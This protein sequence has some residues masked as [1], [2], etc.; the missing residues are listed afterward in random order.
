MS[1][2]QHAKRSF[3]KRVFNRIKSTGKKIGLSG[4]RSPLPAT[5]ASAA[6][7]GRQGA[8]SGTSPSVTS[9]SVTS[10]PTPV[11][12]HVP[13]SGPTRLTTAPDTANDVARGVESPN[14]TGPIA[15][16][17]TMEPT[18]Y[19]VTTSEVRRGVDSRTS[20]T[21]TTELTPAAPVPFS[22]TTGS[23]DD[24]PHMHESMVVPEKVSAHNPTLPEFDSSSSQDHQRQLSVGLDP[25]LLQSSPHPMSSPGGIKQH[26]QNVFI[27]EIAF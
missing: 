6:N 15:A 2:P 26:W 20:P 12:E 1:S 22:G 17:R 5:E 7:E 3:V 13:A 14:A 24:R 21:P 27:G 9:P 18:R 11:A 23:R 16:N 19:P 10:E 8:E 4:R 25:K